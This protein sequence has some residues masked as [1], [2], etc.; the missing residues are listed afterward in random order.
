MKHSPLTFARRLFPGLV[1]ALTGSLGW[2]EARACDACSLAFGQEIAGFRADSLAAAD[3]RRAIENQRKINIPGLT[4]PHLAKAAEAA[5]DEFNRPKPEL[6]GGAC[7][8]EAPAA[9]VAPATT[10]VVSGEAIRRQIETQSARRVASTAPAA[11]GGPAPAEMKEAPVGR[12]VPDYFKDFEFLDI[13]KRDY[14]LPTVPSSTVPQ[15][16][17]VDKSF[18][19]E[20]HEGQVYMGNGVVYDGFLMNGGIPGPTLIVDEGDVV[21]MLIVNKGNIP[22][23]ASIH[24]ANTQTSKYV[25]KIGPGETGRVVFQAN[26]PGVFMYHCAPGG[27]AIAMHVLFGQYGMIMVRPKKQY[28]MERELG[29]APDVELFLIQH[30]W[31]DSGADAIEG[32]PRY[33]TFNGKMFRYIEEPV[34]ARPGDYVRINFLNIGPNLLSTFHIV[35]IIWDYIYWQG[36]PDAILP[37]GQTVTAGPS[38]SFVIEFRIPPDEGAYTMLTHAVGSTNRGAIGLIVADKNHE[39]SGVLLADGPV[40]TPDEMA[41]IAA[42]AVRTI[43]PFRPGTT[44][45]ENPT[46]YGP[47]V[48]T[49][50]VRILGN[51]YDPKVIRIAPGTTVRWVNEDAFTYFAGEYSGIHNAVSMGVDDGFASPLLAHGESYSHTFT[52]E[53]DWK[54]LCTPHPYMEGRIEVVNPKVDMEVIARAARGLSWWVVP[55]VAAAF[56]LA[57]AS[58]IAGRRR[59]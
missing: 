59:T 30:E 4:S 13:I 42:K 5:L 8:A 27:H 44:D 23:G 33:V 17:P 26:T 46:V 43:S 49:V 6:C 32:R 1:L 16:A 57:A 20:L 48:D 36:H 10:P 51:S 24:A 31:Y 39:P 56:A 38:D 14:A 35:G 11:V 29:K 2:S 54:Y 3:I 22:H 45:L 15:D 41:T 9:A 12:P 7:C 34:L 21:E 28:R 40:H 55:L 47:E 25:G 58:Y 37:G 18:T 53:G 19:V 52:A 50:T